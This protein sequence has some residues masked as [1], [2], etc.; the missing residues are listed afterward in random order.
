MCKAD[1]DRKLFTCKLDSAK[2]EKKMRDET[3]ANS[4]TMGEDLEVYHKRIEKLEKML[5]LK[6]EELAQYKERERADCD[7]LI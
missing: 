7:H 1:S 5:E 2:N 4:K 3:A 6:T